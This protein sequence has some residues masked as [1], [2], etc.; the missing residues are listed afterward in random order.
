MVTVTRALADRI[1][2]IAELLEADELPDEALTRLTGLGAEL[3][4]GSAVAV[5]IAGP[6]QPL[7]YAASDDRI[8][9]LHELQFA[10]GAGPVVETLL[11]NE[12]RRVDD[13]AAERRWPQFCRAATEAGF[14]SCLVLPLRTGRQPSGAVAF[15]SQGE[16]AF[17]EAAH[18]VA[19]LFA[20][21]GGTAV[22]NAALYGGCRQMIDNLHT[23][24]ASR[25]VIEQAKGML[26]ADFGVS[27]EQAFQ[28]LSRVSQNTNQKVRQVAADLVDG[29][30]TSDRFRPA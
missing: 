28:L 21:Q 6:G 20:A 24:L 1:A 3:L 27:P 14:G 11:H 16:R 5:T 7:T 4:A 22:H 2:G 8:S 15:Y 9:A 23:A 12:P 30:I 18:D 17:G 13:T 19:L 26:H 25:A 29:R 10:S